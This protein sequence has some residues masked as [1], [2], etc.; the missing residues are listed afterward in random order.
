M[1]FSF[2][3]IALTMAAVWHIPL[4]TAHSELKSSENSRLGAAVGDSISL[5][6][7]TGLEGGEGGAS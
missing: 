1:C 2:L 4:Q 7:P 5:D 6:L 3:F